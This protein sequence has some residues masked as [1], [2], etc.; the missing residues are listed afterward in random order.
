MSVIVFVNYDTNQTIP[1]L[2]HG[3]KYTSRTH[4]NLQNQHVTRRHECSLGSF[5]PLEFCRR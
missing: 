4:T 1:N 2:Q 3:M 5:K